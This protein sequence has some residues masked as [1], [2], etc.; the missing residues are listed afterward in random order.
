MK[1]SIKLSYVILG[2]LT[3]GDMARAAL[4]LKV[5][6]PKTYGQKTI[7]KMDLRNTFT[8]TI[9]SARAVVFL[10]DDN[11]KVVGQETR[12]IIGGTKDRPPLAPDA[13]TTFNFVVQANKPFTKTKVTVTRLVLEGGKLADVNK[14]VEIQLE[15]TGS[16]E[17]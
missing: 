2:L 3:T 6:E 10:L 9:E 17:R 7:V 5:A 8:N 12:W 15:A 14:D 16:R 13:K 11:G 4:T 1:Y